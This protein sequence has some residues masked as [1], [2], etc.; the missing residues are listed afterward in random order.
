ML[1]FSTVIITKDRPQY[2]LHCLTAI[3][4]QS[5]IPHE[6]L[7]VDNSVSKQTRDLFKLFKERTRLPL[8]YVHTTE[9]GF[10]SLRQKGMNLATYDWVNFIDDDCVVAPNYF[11][12]AQ[13]TLQKN[14]DAVA[15][16]GSSAT[17]FPRQTPAVLKNF[18]DLVWKK[19]AI[20]SDNIITD[21]E[22]LDDKN[23]LLNKIFLQKN[24]IYYDTSRTR[25]LGAS[26]DN[27]LGMQIQV[28]HGKAIYNPKMKV[29]HKDFVTW[30]KYYA[31]LIQYTLAHN[32]YEKKWT[33]IRSELR[34]NQK[35]RFAQLTFLPKYLSQ[36][37]LTP[38]QKIAFLFHLATSFLVVKFVKVY[39]LL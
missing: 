38:L 20:D 25:F 39:A 37:Q 22:I 31:K 24:H 18:I 26:Q 21:L 5:I 19:N 3:T 13:K 15:I 14:L 4:A 32:N 10:P 8:R 6:I 30:K 16:L 12:E 7:I 17:F 35:K 27:D 29:L 23:V 34:L 1:K 2:L 11:F 33:S 28:H 9:K 36:K